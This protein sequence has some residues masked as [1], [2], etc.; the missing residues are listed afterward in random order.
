MTTSVRNSDC[1]DPCC[2]YKQMQR[3]RPF[4]IG[5]L[6]SMPYTI[7]SEPFPRWP[8]QRYTKAQNDHTVW[9]LTPTP[10][11]KPS[12]LSQ[13]CAAHLAFRFW[14][15]VFCVTLWR[16]NFSRCLSVTHL[17]TYYWSIFSISY[18]NSFSLVKIIP[19]KAY[20]AGTCITYPWYKLLSN[21][22]KIDYI[23]W[24]TRLSYYYVPAKLYWLLWLL[25]LIFGF[26][27]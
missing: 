7:T 13:V 18:F 5:E 17:S 27:D 6:H 22:T 12:F 25:R 8:R 23:Q 14:F 16:T 19:E 1:P 2:L 3:D 21:M 10:I 9:L 20:V 11:Q 15:N 4:S 24:G 26:G